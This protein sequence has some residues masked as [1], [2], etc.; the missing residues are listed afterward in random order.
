MS[1]SPIQTTLTLLI[2]VGL[3]I[4]DRLDALDQAAEDLQ[5]LNTNLKLLLTVFENPLH[6]DII[7]AHNSEFINILDILE[8]IAKSC[9]K[10]AAALD[11]N[12]GGEVN[13]TR[14]I[15]AFGKKIVRRLWTFNKIPALLAEI[16][17]KAE[18]LQKVYSV[19]SLVIL[20]DIKSQRGQINET[21]VV[22]S[23][24]VLGESTKHQTSLELD[25]S[26]NFAGIDL[27][28]KSLMDECKSLR[29]KLQDAI[30]S[31]NT[32]AIKHFEQQNPEGTSF[33]KDRFQK[34]E[35]KASTLRYEVRLQFVSYFI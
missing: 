10:C 12:L 15:E 20:Q 23:Q 24:T 17:R 29:Q 26:T 22:R 4:K 2:K 7:K 35:L 34:E 30:I 18:H 32:L 27:M 1:D 6:E 21:Q 5:L 16:Q 8:G 14:N 19:V 3:E 31:P 11:I 33:W 13:T 28:V 9:A 25:L